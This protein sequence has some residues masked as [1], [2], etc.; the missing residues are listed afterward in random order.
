VTP[1]VEAPARNIHGGAGVQRFTPM[2]VSSAVIHRRLFTHALGAAAAC[3]L[4]GL[5]REARAHTSASETLTCP[6]DAT[7]LTVEVTASM[8][9]F[10][11]FRDFQKKGAIGSYYADL[12]HSCPSCKFAGFLDDFG[13]PVSAATRKWVLGDH[14][15]KWGARAVSAA[16]ECEMAAERYLFERG[17]QETIGNL[18]TIG[19]YLLRGAK[20]PLD[21]T[22]IHYQRAGA[23]HLDLALG[24]GEIE[25]AQRGPV[26][27]LVAE[28][29]RRAGDFAM[30]IDHFDAAA[31]EPKSPPWL[32]P[33]IT[34]QR[35]LA[36]KKDA[37]NLI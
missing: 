12:V 29:A 3:V 34:E 5:G 33:L 2:R 20:G 18:Y 10:G 11:S 4:V 37:N 17:K 7:R 24:R 19:S 15:K 25:A 35:A 1:V 16:E 6:V 27:Y 21:A 23:K 32:G 26:Q 9:T 22:R 30:A 36:V 14:K 28:L 8:T 31:V 13:K